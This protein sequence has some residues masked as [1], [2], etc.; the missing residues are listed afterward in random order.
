MTLVCGS[1]ARNGITSVSLTSASLP[2]LRKRLKPM[3]WP[4]VQSMIPPHSA[5]D[6]DRK[7][8]LPCGGIPLTKV[9]FSGVCV[10]MTP[11]PLGP[12]TRIP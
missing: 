4:T 5:P 11:M 3:P 10:S 7:A 6:C 12:M 9:V 8:M 2:T 1:A